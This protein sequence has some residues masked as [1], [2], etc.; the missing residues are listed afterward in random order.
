MQY[1]VFISYSHAADGKL[2]P[3]VQLGLQS[4]AKPWYRLRNLSVF[5]DETSLSATPSL[6]GS[7]ETAL[8][9]ARFFL[10][11]ASPDSAKSKWVSKEVEYWLDNKPVENLLIVLTNGRVAWD[12]ANSDFDRRKSDAIPEVLFGHF[13]IEPLWVDFSWASDADDVSIR[14]SRFRTDV[15]RLAAPVH[16]QA[17]EEFVGEDLRQH[18]RTIRIAK[19]AVATLVILL[20]ASLVAGFFAYEQ[21]R[22]AER[23]FRNGLARESAIRARDVAKDDSDLALVLAKRSAELTLNV[24]S[25]VTP[26]SEAI[27][28]DLLARENVLGELYPSGSH[29]TSW[30]W[31]WSAAFNEDG[32]RFAAAAQDGVGI[33]D[34]S[35][36]LRGFYPQEAVSL[37]F[38]PDGHQ[39]ASVGRDGSV[40]II[41]ANGKETATFQSHGAKST[42]IT[43]FPD[44][45]RLLVT[46]CER[47]RAYLNCEQGPAKIW[48]LEGNLITSLAI[49][50]EFITAACI[51]PAGD[52]MVTVTEKGTGAIWKS[53]GELVRRIDAEGN[54]ISPDCFAEDGKR[55]VIGGCPV[56][57]LPDV[58]MW[59][60]YNSGC[61]KNASVWSIRGSKI[62]EIARSDISIVD[63]R[64]IKDYRD[65]AISVVYQDQVIE[66]FDRNGGAPQRLEHE[67]AVISLDNLGQRLATVDRQGVGRLWGFD[68]QAAGG[69]SAHTS[70]YL[71]AL[72][73][74]TFPRIFTVSCDRNRQGACLLGSIRV[75]GLQGPLVVNL[76][77]HE[78][79]VRKARFNRDSTMILTVDGKGVVRTWNRDGHLIRKISYPSAVIRDSFFSGNADGLVTLA[80]AGTLESVAAGCTG[81]RLSVWRHKNMEFREFPLHIENVQSI[82][83]GPSENRLVVVSCLRKAR[84]GNYCEEKAVS[85]VDLSEGK[86]NQLGG[87]LSEGIWVAMDAKQRHIIVVSKGISAWDYEGNKIGE[88]S[89]HGID[90]VSGVSFDLESNRVLVGSLNNVA[91]WDF[92]RGDLIRKVSNSGAMYN[93]MAVFKG[94]MLSSTKDG[95]ELWHEGSQVSTILNFPPSP[96]GLSLP[97]KISSDGSRIVALGCHEASASAALCRREGLWM[98]QQDGELVNVLYEPSK[99]VEL[100]IASFSFDPTSNRLVTGESSGF[101]RLWGVSGNLLTTLGK[102]QGRASV[103][104][105]CPDGRCLLTAGS[106]GQ[107]KV[108]RV[109]PDI[110]IM[111]D[112]VVNRTVRRLDA[113]ECRR[114]FHQENCGENG[115]RQDEN[116]DDLSRD[117]VYSYF[118][119]LEEKDIS[120][121]VGLWSAD[122]VKKKQLAES[123]R[124]A[125]W[126]R[127]RRIMPLVE[128]ES[129]SIYLVELTSKEHG[130]QPRSWNIRVDMSKKYGEWRILGIRSNR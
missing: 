51:S 65:D 78:A 30:S 52:H 2:A 44:G 28:Y 81:G 79:G 105:F 88:I 92:D 45:R 43:V 64:F 54:W 93:V 100:G 118:R 80:C 72:A 94:T 13:S 73:D 5:R 126:Y 107:A 32:S 97:P 42:S 101:V 47:E 95:A 50:G 84:N 34:S 112:E 36:R 53:N 55:F 128:M 40:R 96:G 12:S 106:S 24:D 4:I 91:L 63:A 14:N 110:G 49:E 109:F 8:S 71:F 98:W 62:A 21:K 46:G 77:G 1:D 83:A 39:L 19:V 89:S 22:E 124:N 117:V 76:S 99:D 18:R 116:T 59:D 129:D 123:I 69:F 86:N 82:Q 57:Q 75:R 48:D 10:L 25:K 23:Q 130:K 58:G 90:R 122:S 121:A 27:L 41:D 17:L 85:V 11:F 87:P 56:F 60:L 15:A 38:T 20:M 7:I 102:H 74:P 68:L 115:G 35:L 26:E 108:W 103:T 125:Q 66:L 31:I 111:L 120:R 119:S 9:K 104:E 3:A 29:E 113:S 6:W 61:A 127:M 37:A 33:W 70:Y 114:Y 16:G 67:A